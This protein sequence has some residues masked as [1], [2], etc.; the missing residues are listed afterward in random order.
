VMTIVSPSI[1]GE[2]MFGRLK[3]ANIFES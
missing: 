3:I 1:I 2:V